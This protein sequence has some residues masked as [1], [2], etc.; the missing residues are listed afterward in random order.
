MI[1]LATRQHCQAFMD[2][3]YFFIYFFTKQVQGQRERTIVHQ[4]KYTKKIKN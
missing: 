1:P 3:F 4:V 2:G